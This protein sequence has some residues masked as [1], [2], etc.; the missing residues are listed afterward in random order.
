MSLTHSSFRNIEIHLVFQW[1][2]EASIF[3]LN[4]TVN[5]EMS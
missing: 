4:T 2:R 1:I 5:L 3:I